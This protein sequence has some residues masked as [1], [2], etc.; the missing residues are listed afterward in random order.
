MLHW[1][2]PASSENTHKRTEMHRRTHVTWGGVHAAVNTDG[3]CRDMHRTTCRHE[4]EQSVSKQAHT[5]T[6]AL[7]CWLVVIMTWMKLLILSKHSQT[8]WICASV[9]AAT[10]T[11]TRP[12]GGGSVVCEGSYPPPLSF[13]AKPLL[14]LFGN[15]LSP[16]WTQL[17]DSPFLSPC[18]SSALLLPLVSFWLKDA[19]F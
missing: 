13:T 1:V 17:S 4:C 12:G 3:R 11:N 9:C 19:R 15:I 2:Q 6:E 8:L 7:L 16:A 5:H 10:C 18:S 14:P